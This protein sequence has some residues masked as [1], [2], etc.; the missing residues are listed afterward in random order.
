MVASNL[1]IAFAYRLFTGSRTM[2]AGKAARALPF[3]V[4]AV[5]LLAS[6]AMV[7]YAVLVNLP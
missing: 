5:C 7:A 1:L 4:F 3:A 2:P 6:S